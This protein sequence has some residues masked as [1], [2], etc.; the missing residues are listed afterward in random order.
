MEE[1]CIALQQGSDYVQ[2]DELN[3][4]KKA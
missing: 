1:V 4:K 2:D 3:L